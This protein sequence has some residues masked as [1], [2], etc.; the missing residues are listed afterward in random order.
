[1]FFLCVNTNSIEK[2]QTKITVDAPVHMRNFST[3]QVIASTMASTRKQLATQTADPQQRLLQL[4]EV[5]MIA[6][7]SG[8]QHIASENQQPSLC[9]ICAGRQCPHLRGA[10][11]HAF[12]GHQQR[13]SLKRQLQLPPQSVQGQIKCNFGR[14]MGQWCT[15]RRRFQTTLDSDVRITCCAASFLNHCA[16]NGDTE[17]ASSRSFAS[18]VLSSRRRMSTRGTVHVENTKTEQG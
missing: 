17:L 4:Q 14:L 7:L 18:S 8:K 15:L 13:Q 3:F 5:Q 6:L 11:P 2:S 10:P 9:K 1:M 16:G 12:Q